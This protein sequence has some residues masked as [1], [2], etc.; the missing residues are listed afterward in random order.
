MTAGVLQCVELQTTT[1]I[2]FALSGGSQ[3]LRWITHTDF[4]QY[5]RK[6]LDIL[7]DI[8][9]LSTGQKM[10]LPTAEGKLVAFQMRPCNSI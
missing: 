6:L 5:V 4:F 7:L 1:C 10:I 9:E 2:C 8:L 3:I